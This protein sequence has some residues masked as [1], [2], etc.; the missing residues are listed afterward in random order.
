ML[1]REIALEY[2][3]TLRT[4]FHDKLNEWETEFVASVRAQLLS[5]PMRILTDKQSA[6]LDAIMERCADTH[7]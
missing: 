6:R 4:H 1:P 2:C 3:N 5:D 7:R